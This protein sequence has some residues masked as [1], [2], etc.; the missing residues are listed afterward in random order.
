MVMADNAVVEDAGEDVESAVYCVLR[1]DLVLTQ[2]SARS[3]QHLV[4]GI[5]SANESTD[6]NSSISRAGSWLSGRRMAITCRRP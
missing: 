6:G 2:H 4:Q 1:E 5:N 3:T